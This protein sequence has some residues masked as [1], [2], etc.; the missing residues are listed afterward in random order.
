MAKEIGAVVSYSGI[1]TIYLDIPTEAK[2][3]PLNSDVDFNGVVIFVRNNS[4]NHWLFDMVNPSRPYSLIWQDIEKG[5]V[6]G[7]KNALLI[8]KDQE[9]WVKERK[10]YGTRHTRMDLLY[11]KGGKLQN[12]TIYPYN[13]SVSKP[14]I[15]ISEVDNKKKIIRNISIIR[16]EDSKYITRC[17]R[18]VNQNNV[19]LSNI[20][21][22]TPD[23][24]LYGDGA[25]MVENCSN[26][27]MDNITID[28]TYSQNNKYGYG[29]SLYNVWNVVCKN[30]IANGKW[31]IF[32]NNNV[33]KVIL[34]NCDINRFDIHCYG[35]DITMKKCI[36]RRLYNQFSSVFGT[37]VYD[38]CIFEHAIP[39]LI[40]SSYNAYTP[41]DVVWKDC[42]FYLDKNRNY[43]I[44]LLGVPEK[45][46]ERLELR[47]KSLP[48]ISIKNCKVILDGEVDKWY[49]IKTG[50][51]KYKDSFDYIKHITMKG[52]NVYG[53]KNAHFKLCT[54]K[55]NTTHRLNVETVIRKY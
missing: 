19:E 16:D 17:F 33:N 47:F 55:I 50:G 3:I 37:I 54:E 51:N 42:T 9:P 41:F 48:N 40:E 34:E 10:G 28:G 30:V 7:I 12:N 18:I 49:L 46:N 1:D 32:G 6:N 35:K 22:K 20:S 26:V 14:V 43:L 27:I 4:K 2:T 38:S 24:S 21:L 44:T 29:I 5:V 36:V 11:V 23:S 31:G 53:G 45:Y 15:F 8:V 13:S 39:L 25:I 52:I